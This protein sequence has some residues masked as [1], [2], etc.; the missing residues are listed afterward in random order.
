MLL[1]EGH[2]LDP[3]KFT[4]RDP[5][6]DDDVY[7]CRIGYSGSKH[8]RIKIDWAKIVDIKE[9]IIVYVALGKDWLHTILDIEEVLLQKTKE[10]AQEW[11][12]AR[13]TP[14]IIEDFFT[15]SIVVHKKYG[16][17]LKL[18]C[19]NDSL[20]PNLKPRIPCS[21]VLTLSGL[22]F[23]KK[24]FN[25]MWSIES[26]EPL[27]MS[28]AEEEHEATETEEEGLDEEDRLFLGP[29]A[30]DLEAIWKDLV[31]RAQN[32]IDHLTRHR[33][34]LTQQRDIVCQHLEKVQ[35]TMD[36]LQDQELLSASG[37]F[38][39]LEQIHDVLNEVSLPSE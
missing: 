4:V 20:Q 34:Q 17:V 36:Q 15:S 33:D 18:T 31:T 16:H 29:D 30:I 32:H 6:R 14:D 19:K 37:N 3:S 24:K 21:M 23:Y 5:K 12:N 22:K 11:F 1:L 38:Y 2:S 26:Y 25:L 8:V 9:S 27:R 13:M 28:A 7:I 35:Q 39:L 10:R